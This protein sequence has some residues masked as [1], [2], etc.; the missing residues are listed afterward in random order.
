[1]IACPIGGIPECTGGLK[2]VTLVPPKDAAALAKAMTAA[3]SAA[4]DPAALTRAR[5]QVVTEHSREVMYRKALRHFSGD[6]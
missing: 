4:T 3:F 6:V 5:E 2:S 1:V